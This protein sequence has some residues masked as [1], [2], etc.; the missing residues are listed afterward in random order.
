MVLGITQS[1]MSMA[2]IVSPIASGLLI[3]HG[4]LSA[5]AWMASA[6]AVVGVMLS[7]QG[8]SVYS[9]TPADPLNAP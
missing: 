1:L 4:M 2:S 7:R 5:W 6:L 9:A 8:W 3:E